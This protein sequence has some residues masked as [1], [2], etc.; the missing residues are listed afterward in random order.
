[1][2]STMY[3]LQYLFCVRVHVCGKSYWSVNGNLLCSCHGSCMLFKNFPIPF[4]NI[5]GISHERNSSA[6]HTA[7]ASSS[8]NVESIIMKSILFDSALRTAAQVNIS[9]F[10]LCYLQ[11]GVGVIRFNKKIL[12]S[13]EMSQIV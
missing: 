6:N 3:I 1:M 2:Y 5:L 12:K 10:L 11:Y 7:N 4:K 9:F 8:S 13:A